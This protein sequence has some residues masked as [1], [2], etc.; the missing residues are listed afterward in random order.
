L[1]VVFPDPPPVVDAQHHLFGLQT[2]MFLVS[3]LPLGPM[4]FT[5]AHPLPQ[6]GLK[7]TGDLALFL[8]PILRVIL[9]KMA[10][11]AAGGFP[12]QMDGAAE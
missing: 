3:I 2:G 1:S 11:H 7:D 6:S 10:C 5:V 9:R 8:C 12:L 4:S